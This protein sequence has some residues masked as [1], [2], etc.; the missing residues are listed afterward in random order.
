MKKI[1]IL[2][3]L[4]AFLTAPV[5]MNSCKSSKVQTAKVKSKS[6][7]GNPKDR[8]NGIWGAGK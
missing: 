7:M 6:S 8:N 3:I 1:K 4:V 5:L 2:A